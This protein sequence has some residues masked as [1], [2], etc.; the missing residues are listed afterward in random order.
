MQLVMD[1]RK[2]SAIVNTEESKKNLSEQGKG[3]SK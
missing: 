2:H 1:E 3:D